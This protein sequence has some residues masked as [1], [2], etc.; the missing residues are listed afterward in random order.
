[1]R[2]EEKK[3]E[4][5]KNIVKD[6]MS[7]GADEVELMESHTENI[8][9]FS[10]KEKKYSLYSEHEYALR[11]ILDKSIGFL[12]FNTPTSDI[13]S[14][15]FKMAKSAGPNPRWK[16]L[17][18][19]QKVDFV[20][21]LFHESME[22]IEITDLFEGLKFSIKED[23][24]IQ[25]VESGGFITI[26]TR[27]ITNSHGLNLS[28]K[29]SKT[30]MYTSCRVKSDQGSGVGFKSDSGIIYDF[31][32]QSLA[33]YAYE[34]AVTSLKKTKIED[35][36]TNVVIAPV[37]FSNII[38]NSAVPSFLG[39]SVQEGVSLM[40]NELKKKIAP[41]HFNLIEDPTIPGRSQSRSFDD[42]GSPAQKVP[43]IQKGM[44]NGFLYDTLYGNLTSGSTGSCV[45]YSKYR[46][47]NLRFLPQIAATA[48]SI[49]GT[50]YP[51]CEVLQ[52]MKRGVILG[53]V[54][55]VHAVNPMTGFFSLPV[56]S[57]FSVEH[58]E[59]TGG[60][61]PFLITG[62]SFEMIKGISAISTERK[63]TQTSLW[64][65][66]VDTGHIHTQSLTCV[67]L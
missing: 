31:D 42:E 23:A 2:G 6:I 15:A 27:S 60:I 9:F 30:G 3:R 50:S 38:V 17:P 24:R 44:L 16:S 8:S 20:P 45:R 47:K 54:A 34:E 63:R 7:M 41:A 14:L 40:G 29:S 10:S 64:P 59:I 43:I 62:S 65:T 52:E 51:L 55:N 56:T 37:P 28:E 53:G 48:L 13:A 32:A 49:Q 26:N 21:G 19:P 58:G 35:G 36:E 22:D 18:L 5:G 1:M 4:K 11:V 33:E 57:G 67:H 61:K 66:V 39:D 46:G 25:R 12:Y